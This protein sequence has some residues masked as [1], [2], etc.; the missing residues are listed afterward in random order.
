[1]ADM[2]NNSTETKKYVQIVWN[3]NIIQKYI[4]KNQR[5]I[6]ILVYTAFIPETAFLTR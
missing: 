4:T 2:K 3:K 5:G 1:M 6:I